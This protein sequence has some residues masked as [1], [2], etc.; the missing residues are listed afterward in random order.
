MDDAWFFLSRRD[1]CVIKLLCTSLATWKNKLEDKTDLCPL[2]GCLPVIFSPVSQGHGMSWRASRRELITT[3][4]MDKIPPQA[5]SKNL[6]ACLLCSIIQ[7]P[8]DFRKSGCPNC[9]EILQVRTHS[10]RFH[11]SA[12]L[13]D[14]R[15]W[16]VHQTV[17]HH[18]Q[19]PNSTGLSLSLTQTTAGSR[20]GNAQVRL[21][22][23]FGRFLA[24][25]YKFQR[26]MYVEYTLF[27]LRDVYQKMSSSNLN[28]GISNIVLEIKLTRI[29][30]RRPLTL[31]LCASSTIAFRRDVLWICIS[32]IEYIVDI[33]RSFKKPLAGSFD[34]DNLHKMTLKHFWELIFNKY[35][36]PLAL[37]QTAQPGVQ[38][39]P[40]RHPVCNLNE[41]VNKYRWYSS[42]LF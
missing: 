8:P 10:N 25:M 16:K 9:E 30:E 14:L 26:N 23:S 4:I 38:R 24:L 1:N 33:H 27:A 40:G 11:P 7:L 13:N 19:P 6:R 29:K 28:E 31:T 21:A 18:V 15:R 2:F 37:K 34:V 5:R 42:P 32:R 39:L 35:L 41:V 22:F 12:L 3:T 20:D 36:P 17:L